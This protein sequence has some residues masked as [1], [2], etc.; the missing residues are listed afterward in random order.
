MG[1]LLVILSNCFILINQ[2][3]K[4]LMQKLD[5]NK[6][7]VVLFDWDGT[8]A[9]TRTPRLW[10]VNQ[11]MPR[12]GLPDW[13]QT[14]DKQDKYLSF[15]DNF[16][17]VF[18]KDKAPEAYRQYC[19]IYLQN[20]AR[21]VVLFDGVKECLTWLKQKGVKI[22]VMTNKDRKLLDFELPLLLSP[23][24]FDN[25]VCGHEAK[26]DKPSGEHALAALNGLINQ[27]EI[28][29][30]SVW[31]VGDSLLDNLCALDINARP[32]RIVGQAQKIEKADSKE[33]VYFDSFND[34]YQALKSEEKL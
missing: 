9:Q 13:E 21:M 27:N 25:I 23:A 1:V 22:A 15:M 31:I 19:E 11:I 7:K 34:F 14:K 29:P 26:Q 17:L 5:V 12:Y 4:L 32:I 28:S 30:E 16:P 10:A 20:V 2:T 6:L 3:E 33:V 18:G 24:L 8:L